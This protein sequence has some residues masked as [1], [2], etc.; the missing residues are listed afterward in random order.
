[1]SKKLDF[2][3]DQEEDEELILRFYLNKSNAYRINKD[4]QPILW[5]DIYKT[6]YSWA[7]LKRCRYSSEDEWKTTILFQVDRDIQSKI[8]AIPSAI[9]KVLDNK[10]RHYIVNFDKGIEWEVIYHE[11]NSG[12]EDEMLE[13][14]SWDKET[15]KGY[16]F[17]LYKYEVLRFKDYINNIQHYMLQHSIYLER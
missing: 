2:V 5:N 17:Y 9:D 12:M 10:T 14:Q 3:I 13:F 8:G 7:I 15:H 16:K 6:E 1:M 11:K 4:S